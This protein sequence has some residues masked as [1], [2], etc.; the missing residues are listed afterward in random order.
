M[1][2][3][4]REKLQLELYED[5]KERLLEYHEGLFDSKK[6]K[7]EDLLVKKLYLDP[8]EGCVPDEF[9]GEELHYAVKSK[10]YG[11]F[12]VIRDKVHS[13][14]LEKKRI[15]CPSISISID[16]SYEDATTVV[17]SFQ[18]AVLC[19]YNAKAWNFVWSS[20][21]ELQKEMADLFYQMRDRLNQYFVEGIRFAKEK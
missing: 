16:P 12:S 10:F 13:E 20:V 6:E 7:E 9:I 1:E 14:Y 8:Q 19:E 21:A 11:F 5:L 18:N 3:P 4:K 2:Y 17:V 15:S